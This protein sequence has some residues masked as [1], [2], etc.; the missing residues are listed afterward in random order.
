MTQYYNNNEFVNRLTDSGGQKNAKGN[1][2]F[3]Y[4][5]LV[6]LGAAVVGFAAYNY[7]QN[8]IIRYYRKAEQQPD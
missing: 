2:A 6:V 4:T 8:L 7:K 1:N 5:I 3:M